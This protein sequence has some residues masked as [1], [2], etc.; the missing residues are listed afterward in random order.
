LFRAD[1]VAKRSPERRIDRRPLYEL[2][3][4]KDRRAVCVENCPYELTIREPAPILKRF[5]AADALHEIADDVGE[6]GISLG[7]AMVV[8]CNCEGGISRPPSVSA[9]RGTPQ[10]GQA[11]RARGRG[12]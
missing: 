10:R 11:G 3:G 7:G 8:L 9:S 12:D 1:G 2:G 6:G 5:Q 4:A